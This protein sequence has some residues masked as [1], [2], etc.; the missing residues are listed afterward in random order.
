MEK[1][2]I[3]ELDKKYKEIT[4]NKEIEEIKKLVKVIVKEE[5]IWLEDEFL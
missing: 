3:K 5:E 2:T 4:K 1:A